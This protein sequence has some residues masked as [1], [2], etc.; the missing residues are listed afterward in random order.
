MLAGNSGGGSGAGT[1]AEVADWVS[2][3]GIT[4]PVLQDSAQSL[5]PFMQSGYPTFVLIDRTMT[6]QN[7]DLWPPPDLTSS[8]T[9]SRN[10][11]DNLL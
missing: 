8:G 10:A 5:M 11:I 1:A 3:F 2:S 4:H 6:I 9:T 7:A